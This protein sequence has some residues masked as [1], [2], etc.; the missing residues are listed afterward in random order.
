MDS[1][2]VCFA[3]TTLQKFLVPQ[4][5]LSW[6]KQGN[7]RCLGARNPVSM[8]SKSSN[9]HDWLLAGAHLPEN[10]SQ[11]SRVNLSQAKIEASNPWKTGRRYFP[12]CQSAF[13]K[14][15]PKFNPGSATSQRVSVFFFFG[16]GVYHHRQCLPAPRQ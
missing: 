1:L 8:S 16:G 10:P 9:L 3:T 5:N 4:P 6:K 15:V 12:G 13:P 7:M 2:P 14:N 11:K